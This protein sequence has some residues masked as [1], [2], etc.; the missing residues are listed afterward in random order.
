MQN[1][2]KSHRIQS[3]KKNGFKRNP[4]DLALRADDI[5]KII[6]TEDVEKIKK[7]NYYYCQIC[8]CTVLIFQG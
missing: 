4:E 8:K 5:Q 1:T 3:Q 2:I 7:K 6:D